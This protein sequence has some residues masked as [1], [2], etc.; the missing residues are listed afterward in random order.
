MFKTRLARIVAVSVLAVGLLASQ[1]FR[2]GLW[3]LQD[4]APAWKRALEERDE[5]TRSAVRAGTLDLELPTPPE[6]DAH[7]ELRMLHDAPPLLFGIAYRASTILHD[8]TMT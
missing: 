4:R 2:D 8:Q 1:S 3:D 5:A 6:I 7:G